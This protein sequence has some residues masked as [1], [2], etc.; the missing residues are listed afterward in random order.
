MEEVAGVGAP[1]GKALREED[2]PPHPKF[3]QKKSRTPTSKTF[4]MGHSGTEQKGFWI[5]SMPEPSSNEEIKACIQSVFSPVSE[6]GEFDGGPTDVVDG[7][8]QY[9]IDGTR[10]P[11]AFKRASLALRGSKSVSRGSIV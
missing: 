7:L 11:S 8:R 5:A 2:P 4:V 10:K 1:P 6:R 3:T 9:L